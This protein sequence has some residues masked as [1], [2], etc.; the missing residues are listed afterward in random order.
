MVEPTLSRPWGQEILFCFKNKLNTIA[1]PC[2]G[3]FL[4]FHPISTIY[5]EEEGRE[6]DEDANDGDGGEGVVELD[7]GDDDGHH[8]PYRHD[9]H[10]D[11][12]AERADGVVDEELASG[13]ADGQDDAVKE[14]G[15]RQICSEVIE[16]FEIEVV[17]VQ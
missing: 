8:L 9:D 12:R 14:E 13:W 2:G 3:F 15:N 6:D 10:E 5:S 1:W 11:H 17:S 16:A 7:A 4:R